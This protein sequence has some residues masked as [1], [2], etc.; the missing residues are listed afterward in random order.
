[1][2]HLLPGYYPLLVLLDMCDD[3][4][5]SSASPG[6]D[7]DLCLGGFSLHGEMEWHRLAGAN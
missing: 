5:V 2:V 1:M 3:F 6:M 4:P 7:M